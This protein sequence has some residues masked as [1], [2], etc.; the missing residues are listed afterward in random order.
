MD[1]MG[2]IYIHVFVYEYMYMHW[3]IFLKIKK[4]LWI[5]GLIKD[6][7]QEN[8]LALSGC[9]KLGE[10]EHYYCS[11]CSCSSK[12]K[13]WILILNVMILGERDWTN[14]WVTKAET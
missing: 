4:R 2:Y 11:K 12:S 14:N 7:I 6:A 13:Y 10:V 3:R 5:W 1:K 8:P 9:I